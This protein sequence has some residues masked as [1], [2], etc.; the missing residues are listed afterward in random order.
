MWPSPAA[1]CGGV[2]VRGARPVCIS[3]SVC[4]SVCLCVSVPLCLSLPLSLPLSVS[5]SLCLS[6]CVS[7]SLQPSL[8]PCLSAS[9][10]V[11]GLLCLCLC[12]SFPLA[13]SH[14]QPH[15]GTQKHTQPRARTERERRALAR[16][17]TGTSPGDLIRSRPRFPTC[18]CARWRACPCLRAGPLGDPGPIWSRPPSPA[19]TL[20][21]GPARCRPASGRRR[22]SREGARRPG[23]C[24]HATSDMCATRRAPCVPLAPRR[25]EIGRRRALTVPHHVGHRDCRAP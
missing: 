6:L 9:C 11:S 13:P 20:P 7:R 19:D 1:N 25:P 21:A 4:L 17:P 23:I 10:S 12:L 18:A 8:S 14:T 2:S 16:T 15:A 24:R 3:L 22:A 5:V